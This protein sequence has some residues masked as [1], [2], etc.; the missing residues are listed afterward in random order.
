MLPV[1]V[2]PYKKTSVSKTFI[3]RNKII[4]YCEAVLVKNNRFLLEHGGCAYTDTLIHTKP[5]A[6]IFDDDYR[7]TIKIFN[8]KI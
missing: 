2:I 5:A 3:D 7:N 4:I 1:A 6:K 8:K